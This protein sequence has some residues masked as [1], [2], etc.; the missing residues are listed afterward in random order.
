MKAHI[1]ATQ[2]FQYTAEI[3]KL[4]RPD[5]GYSFTITS[6]WLGAKDP[7]AVRTV[8]QITVDASGLLALRDLIDAEVQ[9]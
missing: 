1:L 8:L 3:R 4:D 5:S 7:T 9:S 2:A 6:T